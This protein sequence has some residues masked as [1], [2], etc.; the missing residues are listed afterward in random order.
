MFSSILPVKDLDLHS[1]KVVGAVSHFI[2]RASL[3]KYRAS[4]NSRLP[5]SSASLVSDLSIVQPQSKSHQLRNQM[6]E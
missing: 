1:A 3:L 5:F 6:K 4:P 2:S